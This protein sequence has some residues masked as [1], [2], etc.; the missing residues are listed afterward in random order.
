MMRDWRGGGQPAA[1]GTSTGAPTVP[2]GDSQ[3]MAFRLTKKETATT[4]SE[5]IVLRRIVPPATGTD[6]AARVYRASGG[7][8]PTRAESTVTVLLSPKKMARDAPLHGQRCFCGGAGES[9]PPAVRTVGAA[10]HRQHDH[11][12]ADVDPRIE[13]RDVFIGKA[14]ATGR[15]AGAMVPARWCRECR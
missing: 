13:N 5:Q 15:H 1:I 8:H 3:S 6:S 14:D 12:G 4:R 7:R 9:A 11:L 2:R 10:V